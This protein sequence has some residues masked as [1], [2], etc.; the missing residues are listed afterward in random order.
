MAFDK[1][2]SSLGDVDPAALVSAV[3]RGV[4]EHRFLVWMENEQEQQAVSGLGVSG[5]VLTD[6]TTAQVGV[7]LNDYSYTKSEYYVNLDTVVG[8]KIQNADGSATYRMATTVVNTMD[9]A[10][11]S[12]LPPYLQAH[13]GGAYSPAT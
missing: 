2:V 6:P 3:Q 13:N 5:V 4:D 8:E 11:E 12:D 1:I 10:M 7:Y 9:P